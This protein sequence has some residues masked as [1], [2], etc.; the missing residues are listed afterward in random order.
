[1]TGS[2]LFRQD[3]LKVTLWLVG[4]MVLGALLAPWVFVGGKAFAEW[5]VAGGEARQGLPLV[6]WVGEEALKADFK[7]YFNRA[8]L[9]AAL[10]L[11]W[12]LVKSLRGGDAAPHGLRL[13]KTPHRFGYLAVGW[14]MASAI[15]LAMGFSF[16]GVGFFRM[17]G[18]PEWG[19]WLTTALI[20][21]FGAAV[22]EEIFFRGL[23]TGALLRRGRPL[24]VMLFVT[25]FFA[26]VHFLKPP[27]A[28]YIPDETVDWRSGFFLTGIILRHMLEPEFLLAEFATLFA[29]GWVLMVARMKTRSLW[30][31][32]GL[33]GGW[34]FGLKLFSACTRRDAPLEETLPWIGN[35]LK[36]GLVPLVLVSVTGILVM[37]MTRKWRTPPAL[38]GEKH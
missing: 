9:V 20:A 6:G 38:Q 11:L 5:V 37:S 19:E 29:V 18:E 25:T 21:G 7:R 12:P 2:S 31:S 32:I 36:T 22:M 17:R 1:M 33:H 28:L 4:T 13:E 35:D 16:V 30:L 3:W 23:L 8:M 10:V 34:V 15:L 27:E 14:V 24:A 26:V